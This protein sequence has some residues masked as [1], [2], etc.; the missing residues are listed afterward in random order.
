M[1][2]AVPHE[3]MLVQTTLDGTAVQLLAQGNRPQM[4]TG[5]EQEREREIVRRNPLAPHPPVVLEGPP[6]LTR[7][8]EA[9]DHR[10][11]EEPI[12]LPRALE[13][14]DRVAHV[15]V[16]GNRAEVDDLADDEQV[17]VLD[18]AGPD[19]ARV[20]LLD[21]REGGAF[22]EEGRE[23]SEHPCFGMIL[24]WKEI[25]LIAPISFRTS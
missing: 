10:V 9:P 24:A 20:D 12:R 14:L 18:P 1:D 5:L 11:P 17:L 19:G 2:E 13:D 3:T 21:V 4:P 7:V 25:I 15:P 22:L 23:I 8:A 6:V 16:L